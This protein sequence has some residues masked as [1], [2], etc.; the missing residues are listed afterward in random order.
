MHV[1]SILKVQ[2]PSF[3]G[4]PAE[5]YISQKSPGTGLLGAGRVCLRRAL[6]SAEPLRIFR[7][8][9]PMSLWAQTNLCFC[10]PFPCLQGFWTL[11]GE[12]VVSLEVVSARWGW[13][14]SVDFRAGS[15]PAGRVG[16]TPRGAR[17]EKAPGADRACRAW[18]LKP[19]FERAAERL[20]V[21]DG[22]TRPGGMSL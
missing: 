3:R 10:V 1:G 15:K 14:G 6:R 12:L 11:R 17:S 13:E 20:C 19:V 8:L 5:D 21:T 2:V 9:F 16:V 22:V 18:I 4:L 7:L